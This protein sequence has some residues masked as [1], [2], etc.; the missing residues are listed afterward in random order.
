MIWINKVGALLPDAYA[1]ETLPQVGELD[2]RETFMGK[3]K[4]SWDWDSSRS[5]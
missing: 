1:P 2:E 5:F 4:Q 3:K